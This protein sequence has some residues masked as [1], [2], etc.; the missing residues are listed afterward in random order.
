MS[1]LF[2]QYRMQHCKFCVGRKRSSEVWARFHDIW[3]QP[4]LSDLCLDNHKA[5]HPRALLGYAR[6]CSKNNL[7]KSLSFSEQL[8]TQKDVIKAIASNPSVTSLDCTDPSTFPF[9]VS[10]VEFFS[11][12]DPGAD[13]RKLMK[14]REEEG[15]VKNSFPFIPFSVSRTAD[16]VKLESLFLLSSLVGS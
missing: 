3:Y 2:I 12:H 6:S 9:C 10:S 4:S 7:F 15:A 11:F 5:R 8:H 13:C 1:G 14:G 16:C